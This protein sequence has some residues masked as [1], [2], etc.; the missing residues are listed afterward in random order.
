MTS[1]KLSYFNHIMQRCRS[2]EKALMLGDVEE[3]SRSRQAVWLV[4]WIDSITVAKGVQLEE[5]KVR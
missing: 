3:K 1:L 2:M 5:L 4:G